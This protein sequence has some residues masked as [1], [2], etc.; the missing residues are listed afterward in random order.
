[1]FDLD[2]KIAKTAHFIDFE[3]FWA[4]L[5]L[6]NGSNSERVFLF[7]LDL[8]IAKTAHL[9][10]CFFEAKSRLLKCFKVW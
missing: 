4:F 8:K 7:D 9:K 5:M 1:M 10:L 3:L 2:L 6:N